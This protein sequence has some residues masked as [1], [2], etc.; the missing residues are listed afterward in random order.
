MVH[1]TSIL[2]RTHCNNSYQWSSAAVARAITEKM[3]EARIYR[4][5]VFSLF[6]LYANSYFLFQRKSLY[7][8][9]PR[10][11]SHENEKLKEKGGGKGFAKKP[12]ATTQSTTPLPN[13]SDKTQL[14]AD[15][16]N[17]VDNGFLS[18]EA[19]PLEIAS[20]PTI[21]KQPFHLPESEPLAVEEAKELTEEEMIVRSKMYVDRRLRKEQ[22]IQGRIDILREEEQIILSEPGGGTLPEYVADR[23]IRRIA[24]FFG[25]PVFGGLGLFVAGYFASKH[26]DITVPPVV[27]GTFSQAPFIIAL[28]GISYG[29]LSS[30]WDEVILLFACV[31]RCEMFGLTICYD[32][33]G[34]RK[35]V[36][37]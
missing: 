33:I 28:L 31:I 20:H 26:Y 2:H 36:G 14:P 23:M 8:G 35:L 11:F 10:L 13:Y 24:L 18:D 17:I 27:M 34:T 30:S 29:I 5:L 25:V 32:C 4:Y 3:V 21:K 22:S 16:A 19:I 6:I 15:I 7:S 1:F 12:D 37:Y 9:L